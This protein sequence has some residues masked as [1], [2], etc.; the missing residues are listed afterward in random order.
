MKKNL[1]KTQAENINMCIFLKVLLPHFLEMFGINH[2]SVK[3]FSSAHLQ[4]ILSHKVFH[5]V[6]F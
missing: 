6:F 4:Q 2:V 3:L 1:N 5:R